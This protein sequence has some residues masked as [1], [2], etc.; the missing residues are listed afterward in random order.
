MAGDPTQEGLKGADRILAPVMRHY[1]LRLG[2]FGAQ[3]KGVFWRDE[4][5]QALRFRIL[6]KILDGA[7]PGMTLT[8][9]GCG[10]GA[11]WPHVRD[12]P[13]LA[14]GRYI[15]TDICPDMLALARDQV[16]DPRATFMRTA[17][18][19]LATDFA[20]VS[21][22][23]NMKL[24]TDN[25]AWFG[26]VKASLAQLWSKT[27]I[28]LAF[29]MLAHDAAYQEQGLYYAKDH[30]F[31]DFCSTHLGANVELLSAYP[32]AEWTLF[33]RK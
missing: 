12:H 15:G 2:R 31:F 20:V 29:N 10:Y 8:D 33:L 32:L 23:W 13:A 4:E 14:G 30:A 3:P 21:G 1:R 17:V 7:G 18:A 11:L 5:G 27:R 16:T 28:G 24:D 26:Y 9:F 25:G 22:T 6:L 19:P